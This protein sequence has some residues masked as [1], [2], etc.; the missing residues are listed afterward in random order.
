[1]KDIIK[2][3]LYQWKE[4]PI[5]ESVP[6]EI[7]LEEYLK[8]EPRKIIAITGFRRV[9]K[10]YLLFH[11][12]RQL[13]K[14]KSKDQV[15]YVNF[16]DERIPLDKGFLT[17]MIPAI[18]EMSREK[19]EIIFLDEIHIMP[20]WSKWLRRIYDNENFRIF[21][22]GSSSKLSSNEIPTE[23]RGRFLEKRVFP[24]NFHEFL[25]FK[26]A[27][28]QLESI[29][30]S[31]NQKAM[32]IG[33]F[34]EFLEYGGLPEVVLS[35]ESKKLE[36]VQSYYNTVVKKDIVERFKVSNEEGLKLIL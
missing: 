30:H 25:N 27:G 20:E 33:F 19:P 7:N 6:R 22:T 16:E 28:I 11:T 8:A 31:E 17:G 29:K 13:L 3:I 26:N 9:G 23:L 10:T 21:V 18:R 12:I 35:P 24:L 34:N 5:P 14:E 4:R 1:M 32:L 15:I 36:I 2:T